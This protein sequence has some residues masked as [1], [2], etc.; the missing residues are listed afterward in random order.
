MVAVVVVEMELVGD[1]EADE[2]GDG[3]AGGQPDD[4]DGRVAFV[5][6]EVPPGDVQIRFEHAFWWASLPRPQKDSTLF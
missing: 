3:E 2:D 6:A 1:P 5:A 4:I